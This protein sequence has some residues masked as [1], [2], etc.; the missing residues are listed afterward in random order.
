MMKESVPKQDGYGLNEKRYLVIHE[1]C[2]PAQFTDAVVTRQYVQQMK[3][4]G[5]TTPDVYRF[6]QQAGGWRK[7]QEI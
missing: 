7:L 2:E 3:L 5:F 1:N 6:D 4:Q